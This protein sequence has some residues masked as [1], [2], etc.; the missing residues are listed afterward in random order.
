MEYRSSA[1][2]TVFPAKRPQD[3]LTPLS[4]S[5]PTIL[6]HV[7]DQIPEL[8]VTPPASD[9]D[10]E[11]DELLDTAVHVLS[12]EAMALASLA[13]LYRQDP[14][15]RAGLTQAIEQISRTCWNGGKVVISGVGKSGKIADKLVATMNSLG[16]FSVFLHPIEALHGDLGIVKPVSSR[17][18]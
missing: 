18:E 1:M 14:S 2:S 6:P 12:T 9:S 13:S 17:S 10:V 11:T 15:A 5:L 16:L 3:P 8:P 4:P 7:T